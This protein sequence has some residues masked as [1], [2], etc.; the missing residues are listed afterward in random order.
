MTAQARITAT[1]ALQHPEP[2]RPMPRDVC[3][4]CQ[5]ETTVHGFAAP[6]GHWIETHHCPV[7]GDVAPMHG[8][9]VNG[10]RL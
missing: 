10:D 2:P 6:D 3:P 4:H 9:I 7:H 5:R 1:L 8:N